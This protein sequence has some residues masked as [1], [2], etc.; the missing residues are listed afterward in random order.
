MFT[1]SSDGKVFCWDIARSYIKRRFIA[2]PNSV[3]SAM[4]V[5]YQ[6]ANLNSIRLLL[7]HAADLSYSKF[8]N[9]LHNTSTSYGGDKRQERELKGKGGREEVQGKRMEEKEEGRSVP[10]LIVLQKDQPLPL[11]LPSAYANKLQLSRFPTRSPRR[12]LSYNI[13]QRHHDRQLNIISGQ[14]RN[15]D[16][17]YRMLFK[18]YSPFIAC[19]S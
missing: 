18:D 10:I 1:G 4:L 17:I 5:S 19:V 15:R 2:P 7:R 13:R 16:F 9:K 8:H 14:L 12:E 3:V 6:Q 11:P